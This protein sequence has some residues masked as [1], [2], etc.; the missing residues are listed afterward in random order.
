[1][2]KDKNDLS[3][4]DV[5]DEVM[6][7]MDRE[8][9]TSTYRVIAVVGAAYLD[10]MLERLFRRVFIDSP[11][12]VDLLLRPDAPLSSNGSRYRLAYCLGLIS[13]DQ[14]DDLKLIA[15]IRN[16][17]AHDFRVYSFAESP[18][19]E[20]CACLKQPGILAAMPGQMFPPETAA[21]MAQYFRDISAT[22]RESYRTSVFALFGSLLRRLK[23][24]RRLGPGEL[25]S[26]DPDAAIGPSRA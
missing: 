21:T 26:Y 18:I 23:Y 3:L 11:D 9:H 16:A 25:F 13:Q 2:P 22:P 5:G 12:D 10:S 15:K 20:Y 4:E 19:R 14:R 8:F 24:V 17:F 7:E 1:M 6:T